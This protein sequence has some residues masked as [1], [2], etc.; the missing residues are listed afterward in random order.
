MGALR[1]VRGRLH[2]RVGCAVSTCSKTSAAMACT[3]DVQSNV[4][5]IT[6]D[7]TNSA[8]WVCSLD[9]IENAHRKRIILQQMV[10]ALP[11]RKYN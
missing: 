4:R 11:N 8:F 3:F 2:L 5:P 7:A 1:L 6:P 9:G 10:S